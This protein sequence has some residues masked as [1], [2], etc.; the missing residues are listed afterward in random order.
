MS[1]S[2]VFDHPLSRPGVTSGSA[3]GF[4]GGYRLTPGVCLMIGA[5]KAQVRELSPQHVVAAWPAGLVGIGSVLPAR[6]RSP[7]HREVALDV[8][9]GPPNLR[10]QPGD[11]GFEISGASR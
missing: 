5:V 11:R 6:L 2:A 8:R 3:R 7:C 10:D 4:R 9:L 1:T